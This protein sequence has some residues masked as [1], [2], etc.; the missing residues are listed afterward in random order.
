MSRPSHDRATSSWELYESQPITLPWEKEAEMSRQ[1]LEK[2]LPG[3]SEVA[4]EL[5]EST[6]FQ[7][8]DA[9][10]FS[11]CE[12]VSG[13][14]PTSAGGT[15]RAGRVRIPTLEKRFPRWLVYYAA[16][17]EYIAIVPYR[18]GKGDIR[19]ILPGDMPDEL[20]AAYQSSRW[21]DEPE[22]YEEFR[23]QLAVHE[24]AGELNRLARNRALSAPV[25]ARVQTTWDA[26]DAQYGS[27]RVAA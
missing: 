8:T 26:I 2:E 21:D 20:E 17:C 6:K 3:V 22:T 13:P 10:M 24:L 23:R 12:Y 9:A 11:I 25:P 7:S 14:S 18:F 15:T 27:H 4:D 1:K 5:I 19:A 16:S